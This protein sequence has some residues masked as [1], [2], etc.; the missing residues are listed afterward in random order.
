MVLYKYDVCVNTQGTKYLVK[1]KPVFLF[2]GSLCN[3]VCFYIIL[4]QLSNV[5]W[6]LSHFR[7]IL[8]TQALDSAELGFVNEMLGNG[9]E[10]YVIDTDFSGAIVFHTTFL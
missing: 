7:Y 3:C 4:R 2:H 5:S 8:S 6:L 9:K 10:Q 1:E